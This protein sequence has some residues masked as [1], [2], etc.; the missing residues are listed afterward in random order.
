M[1]NGYVQIYTGDGKGKTTAAFGLALRASG[2][3]M[4]SYIGQFM[5]GQ[6]Y[7]EVEMLA[8]NPL[9]AVE[10]YGD[11]HCFRKEEVTEKHRRM[12]RA[13]LA[14]AGDAMRPG[15]YGLVVLDEINTAIWFG[16]LSLG[17][18]TEFIREK[19]SHVELVLTGRKA[20]E[21]LIRMADLVTE[22][23][24]VKHYYQQGVLARDGI[25]R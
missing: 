7:G 21:E 2:H 11:P 13:G 19:P 15:N 1:E 6:K 18:V 4:K 22:M 16:L 12:A 9:V 17:M 10:Q 5:K 25:E 14:R 3:G 8:G 20:P 24:E 23:S